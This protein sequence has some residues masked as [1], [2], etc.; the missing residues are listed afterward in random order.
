MPAGWN[1]PWTTLPVAASRLQG[2]LRDRRAET[3]AGRGRG[4]GERAV[5][6]RVAREKVAQRVLDGLR[7]RLRYADRQRRAE[8]VAQP[9]RVLDRRPVVGSG[10][11]DPDRA[12]GGSQLRGPPRLGAPLGQLGVRERAEEAQQVGDA[13][14]V[15][16]AAVLGEPLELLLQ[17]GQ[18]LGVE[19]LAQLRLAE[20]LGQQPRVQGEGGG[21]A[22]GER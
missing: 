15:L 19:Q 18:H 16:D 12:A 9:A 2:T 4:R 17:L 22:L 13:L 7:E 20:Q 14:G 1:S 8:C 5:S 21:A 3:E 11:T 6:A 10:D